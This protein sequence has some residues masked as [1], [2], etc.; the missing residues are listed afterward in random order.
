M[1][2][3][4]MTREIGSLGTHVAAGL[5]SALGIK[6]IDSEI[7]VNK[8]AGSL[9][10]EQSTVQNYLAGSA[11]CSSGGKSI[12]GSSRATRLSKSSVWLSRAMC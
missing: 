8:V 5:A 6:I 3:I 11:Q 12:R 1:A 7:V 2:V 10:V 4:A 9:G